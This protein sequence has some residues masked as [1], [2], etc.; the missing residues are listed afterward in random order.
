MNARKR[1]FV[2]VTAALAAGTFVSLSTALFAREGSHADLARGRYLV[3]AGDCAACH[4]NE[5]GQ[6]FAGGLPVPTPFGTIY[7]TNITPDKETGIGGWTSDDFYK[8]MHEGIAPGGE[9]LY[10]AFPYPWYTKLS[11]DDV[12][13]IRDY[14]MT[15]AP[16]HHENKPAE[17]PWPFSMR[18]VMAGW[19]ALYFKPGTF[20]PNPQKS[21]EWNLGAYLVEG[22]GHCGACHSPK[23]FA[24][25]PKRDK[26]YH[27]G[28]GE[29]WYAT[30]LVG[31]VRDGLGDWSAQDI[32]QYLKTGANKRA[33]AFGPMAEV[34]HDSTQYLSDQDLHAIAVYL[35][36]LPPKDTGTKPATNTTAANGNDANAKPANVDADRFARGRGY[37]IDD[38][39]G[40]HMENGEGLAGVFPPLKGNNVVQASDAETVVHV[41]LTGAKTATTKQNPTGL[42]MPAFDWKLDNQQIADLVTYLRNAWGNH[43]DAISANKVA[44][45]RHTLVAARTK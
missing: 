38:C 33:S 40:C 14:L 4:T 43:G 25:A 13:A 29:N 1:I 31:D 6:P 10:P 2:A 26:A 28:F 3:Q 42:A 44:D 8:A 37:Y 16:V 34:V 17:L 39:A 12:D 24:G 30:S 41:I 11:R 22:L 15:L 45:T 19:N 35:K 9:H 32:V 7:S 18:E 20:Q 27:G 36:D 21:A 5:G 23:N